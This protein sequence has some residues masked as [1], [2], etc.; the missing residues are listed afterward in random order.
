[1]TCSSYSSVSFNFLGNVGLELGPTIFYASPLVGPVNCD[2]CK[3]NLRTV[4]I[5]QG[6]YPVHKILIIDEDIPPPF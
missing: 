3:S 5:Y 4:C 1:M 6:M 2:I